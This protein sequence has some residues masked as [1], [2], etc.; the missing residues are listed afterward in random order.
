MRFS[1]FT[2]LV[3]IDLFNLG[4]LGADTVIMEFWGVSSRWEAAEKRGRLQ[5][6]ILVEISL[7]NRLFAG[8]GQK[9]KKG[10]I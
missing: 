10:H 2:P 5:L 1:G 9:E 8:Q 7:M 3:F 4:G 6:C